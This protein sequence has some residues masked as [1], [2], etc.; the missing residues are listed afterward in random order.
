ME[1]NLSYIIS[2]P[3]LPNFIMYCLTYILFGVVI[4]CLGP[5]FPYMA[6]VEGRNE[7]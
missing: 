2:H 4:T 1:V 7:T 3:K 5:M 6:E